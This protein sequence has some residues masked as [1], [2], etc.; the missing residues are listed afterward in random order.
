MKNDPRSCEGNLCNCVL[1]LRASD[2]MHCGLAST[3]PLGQLNEIPGTL[4][5]GVA[6]SSRVVK[7]SW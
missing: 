5:R 4:R 7:C 2:M 3:S 1:G 6:P